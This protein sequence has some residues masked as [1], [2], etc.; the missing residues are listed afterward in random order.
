MIYVIC[1]ASILVAMHQELSEAAASRSAASGTGARA[2][3]GAGMQAAPAEAAR[4][5]TWSS[6]KKSPRH[7]LKSF[8]MA[9]RFP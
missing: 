7:S 5:K 3:G 4:L 6:I 2:L 9:L 1:L 8:E